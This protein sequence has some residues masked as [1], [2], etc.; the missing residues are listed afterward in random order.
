MNV[1]RRFTTDQRGGVA[2]LFGIAVLPLIGAVGAAIDYSRAAAEQSK[3]QRAVDAAVLTLVREP[4]TATRRQLQQRAVGVFSSVYSPSRGVV[5]G[6]LEV[7]RRGDTIKLTRGVRMPTAFMK[8]VG[9]DETAISA[10]ATA[11]WG[12]QQIELALVVD[13]TGSMR[14]RIGAKVKIEELRSAAL[15]LV[16]DLRRVATATDDV[17]VSVVPFDTEV[18]V[19]PSKYRNKDWLRWANGGSQ[20]ERNAWS[21]YI[22][23]R[24]QPN[25][26]NDDRPVMALPDTLYPTRPASQWAAIGEL[27][28]VQPLASIY[29]RSTY[30][31][32]RTT[33]NS[34]RPRGN[35]NVGLGVAWGAATLTGSIPLDSTPSASS[36]PVKRYMVVLTDGDNTQ[37]WVD[38]KAVRPSGN[39]SSDPVLRMINERTLMAC[40]GAKAAK[41]EVFTIRLLEGD[42]DM[43]RACA[44][45]SSEASGQHYF[46]VQASGQLQGAFD[47]IVQAITATRLTH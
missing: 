7:E 25:D 39:N 38:G 26:V 1:L 35:T 13:N 3:L 12:S 9:V 23:D 41:I 15:K 19:D 32:I 44:S 22:V 40:S 37:K 34:M 28:P 8:I 18:R 10:T 24:Y 4:K 45:S 33:I 21:G 43:L 46:D 2:M 31:A 47:S 29:D 5:G 20:A 42:G 36:R 11:A 16:E 14:E 17:R 30:E 27:A 6:E